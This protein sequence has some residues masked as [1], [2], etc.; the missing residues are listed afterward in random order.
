MDCP[1]AA[2]TSGLDTGRPLP[3]PPSPL[4]PFVSCFGG[5]GVWCGCPRALMMDRDS[6]Q[7]TNA[8]QWPADHA[9]PMPGR[10]MIDQCRPVPCASPHF[11][12]VHPLPGTLSTL[13][14]H[15]RGHPDT[16]LVGNTCT[17]RNLRQR[18]CT[19][20]VKW[21]PARHISTVFS[22]HCRLPQRVI[23]MTPPPGFQPQRLPMRVSSQ[24]C[25]KASQVPQPVTIKQI[26]H[27]ATSIP[28]SGHNSRDLTRTPKSDR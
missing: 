10:S 19:R 5:E 24:S 28:Q 26:N 15:A 18:G 11:G 3:P 16:L 23:N 27:K 25:P 9:T 22:L 2:R 8:V 6:P 4:Q 21:F 20:A 17:S 13:S 12:A 14:S 1:T 7:S